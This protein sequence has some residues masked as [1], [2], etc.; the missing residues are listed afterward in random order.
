M[1]NRSPTKIRRALSGKNVNQRPS[2]LSPKKSGILPSSRAGR[3][4]PTRK[5]ADQVANAGSWQFFE[6]SEENQELT[7]LRQQ[8][9]RE[10]KFK[11]PVLD[12][13]NDTQIMTHSKSQAEG[14]PVREP[15]ADLD[16]EDH[17]GT[18]EF[19][20]G[21]NNDS[22]KSP[23]RSPSKSSPARLSSRFSSSPLK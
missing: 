17:A 5:R 4:S 14:A 1:N 15:M 16:V 20:V 19:Y 11:S 9:L 2:S 12:P 21:E 22:S 7:R 13:E 6:E 10:N 3:A 8:K 23:S 18:W